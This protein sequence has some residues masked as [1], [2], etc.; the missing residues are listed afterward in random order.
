MALLLCSWSALALVVAACLHVQ[1]YRQTKRNPFFRWTQNTAPL[2][3]SGSCAIDPRAT[4][5]SLSDAYRLSFF[6]LV[7]RERDKR[8]GFW[9][10]AWRRC[11]PEAIGTAVK[12][13][14]SAR[15]RA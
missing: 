8:V 2:F 12:K 6:Y 15:V 11:L 3:L 13:G 1:S 9:P 7:K 14:E 10:R 5:V 4:C